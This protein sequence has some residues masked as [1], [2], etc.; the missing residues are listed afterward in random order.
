[1]KRRTQGSHENGIAL[2]MALIMLLVL[3]LLTAGLILATQTE[4][5]TTANYR[6]MIQARYAAEGGAQSAANYISH[7]FSVTPA[8][9]ALPAN[10]SPVLYQGKP[11]LLSANSNVPSNYPDNAVQTA[12]NG[13]LNNQSLSAPGMNSNYSVTAELMSLKPVGGSYL[14][15]WQIVSQGSVP[16]VKSAQVQVVETIEQSMIP[17]FTYGVFATSSACDSLHLDGNITTN[18]YDSSAGT[19]AATVQ[20]YD[21]NLGT[22]GNMHGDSGDSINGTLSTPHA[23]VAGSNCSQVALDGIGAS[24]IHGTNCTPSCINR[25]S[26]RTIPAPT[27]PLQPPGN[28]TSN[29]NISASSYTLPPGTYGNIKVGKTVIHVSAG[30][31]DLN[32][33]STSDAASIVVDSGPVVFNIWGT[34]TNPISTGGPFTLNVNPS[35][36]LPNP[37]SNFQINTASSGSITTGDHIVLSALIDAPNAAVNFTTQGDVYGAV[38]TSLYNATSNLNVHYDRSLLNGSGTLG[39]FHVTSFSWSRF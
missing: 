1:M 10:S 32:S 9:A 4:M 26:P 25:I 12:F 33:F 6:T 17:L 5:L 22:N 23:A 2:I 8:L 15:N 13:A 31:Y 27:M 38:I 24:V 20:N 30:V 21:G 35:T 34:G 3:S 19:Y 14:Q 39:N 28:S 18:S 16:G 7:N 36:G 11:V 29:L 37:P